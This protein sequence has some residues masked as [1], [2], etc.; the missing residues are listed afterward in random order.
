MSFVSLSSH[1][2]YPYLLPIYLGVGQWLAT[3][4]RLGLRQ[5]FQSF[6]L[7]NIV[8]N[9][10]EQTTMRSTLDLNA[11]RYI[12]S[13]VNDVTELSNKC[14]PT[15]KTWNVGVS[16]KARGFKLGWCFSNI[17]FIIGIDSVPHTAGKGQLRS[18][19]VGTRNDYDYM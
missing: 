14:W 13:R 3:G 17:I 11:I 6:Y 8:L 2:H 4:W 7:S 1:H 10:Y 9:N 5:Y 15:F 12:I 19:Q 16:N 18:L